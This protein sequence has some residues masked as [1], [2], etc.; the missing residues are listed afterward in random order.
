MGVHKY[1]RDC[2][3]L[4]ITVPG[5]LRRKPSIMSPGHWRKVFDYK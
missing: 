1:S 5:N 2:S 4:D 3:G